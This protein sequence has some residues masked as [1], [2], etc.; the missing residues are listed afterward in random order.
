VRPAHVLDSLRERVVRRAVG[1]QGVAGGA[2]RGGEREQKV[3][4]GDV[5]VAQPAGLALGGAQDVEQLA[6][7]AGLARAGGDRREPVERG[8]DV[9]ADRLG[10]DLELAQHGLH[11][12][13]G[14][15][16]QHGEQVLGLDLGVVAARGKGER[17]LEGLLRLVREAVQLHTAS[18]LGSGCRVLN[19]SRVD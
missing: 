15:L 8:V 10:R 11:D 17:G 3:L 12:A 18:N 13:L 19:L 14:L 6:R 16:E 4:G 2:G 1:A 5:L 7:V 9:G